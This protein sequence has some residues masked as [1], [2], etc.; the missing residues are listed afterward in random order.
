MSA[1]SL[2]LLGAAELAE[3]LGISPAALSM[4][5]QRNL[6]PP[7]DQELRC[8]PIWRLATIERWEAKR[9]RTAAA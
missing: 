2:D 5:R 8:G 7:P 1:T 4:R 3:R 9:A 6:I